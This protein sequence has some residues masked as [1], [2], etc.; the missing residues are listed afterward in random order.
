MLEEDTQRSWHFR[1][2]RWSLQNLATAGSDQRP[3]FPDYVL[4]AD[5]LALDFDHWAALARSGDESELS[6]SQIEALAAIDRKLTTMSRDGAEFDVELWT[7]AA[8]SSSEHWAEVRR[9]AASALE[10]FG[11]LGEGP[12]VD[13]AAATSPRSEAD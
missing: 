8:L 4:K 10:A 3:L 11:W 13:G 5:D 6:P 7:E 9:L 2:L 1:R 12:P